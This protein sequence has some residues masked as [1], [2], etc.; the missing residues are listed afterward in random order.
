MTGG[1]VNVMRS[2]RVKG[3]YLFN[4]SIKNTGY[5]KRQLQGR[6]IL[7]RFN[8]IYRLPGNPHFQGK[9]GLRH[10]CMLEP[11]H[12]NIIGD[13]RLICHSN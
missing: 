6:S 12:T 1:D 4:I 11:E 13:G 7:R 5:P 8:G 2:F 10:L 3:K 9:F